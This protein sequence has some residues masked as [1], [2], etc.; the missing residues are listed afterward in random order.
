MSPAPARSLAWSPDGTRIALGSNGAI[1]Q[2]LDISNG[3]VTSRSEGTPGNGYLALRGLL[4]E[5]DWHP[6]AEPT[7]YAFGM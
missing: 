1:V 3:Q 2:I 7:I 5:T 4:M 6:Q